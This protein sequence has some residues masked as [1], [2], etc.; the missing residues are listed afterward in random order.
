LP[1]PAL[2]AEPL[3]L[4]FALRERRLPP[5]LPCRDDERDD[6]CW[7]RPPRACSAGCRVLVSALASLDAPLL[8]P[9]Q[10]DRRVTRPPPLVSRLAAVGAGCGCC[11]TWCTGAGV[12]GRMR[13]TAG[14]A[15]LP[16]LWPILRSGASATSVRRS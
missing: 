14:V 11:A 3:R 12:S 10:P 6:D 2:L 8:A 15:P 16:R 7:R 4:P 5:S 13:L 9:S 1:L